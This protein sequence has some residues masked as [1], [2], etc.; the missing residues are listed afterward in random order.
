MA[1]LFP[2]GNP[3]RFLEP[4]VI[5]S[6]ALVIDTNLTLQSS[7]VRIGVERTKG[8]AFEVK[9]RAIRAKCCSQVNTTEQA[10]A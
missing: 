9:R 5:L 1:S 3:S 6:F 4:R 10:V 2:A 8:S 7:W